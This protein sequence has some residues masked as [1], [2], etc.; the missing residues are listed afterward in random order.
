MASMVAKLTTVGSVV[1]DHGGGFI[2]LHHRRRRSIPSTSFV[3]LSHSR[4]ERDK[5]GEVNNECDGEDD[6]NK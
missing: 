6:C 4:Q 2:V 3:H 5:G 1:S